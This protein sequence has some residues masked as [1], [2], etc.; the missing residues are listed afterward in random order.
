[1]NRNPFCFDRP[2]LGEDFYDR[3]G[4]I[5]EAVGLIKKP[6]CFSIIG[7]EGI[8]KTS[9][10]KRIISKEVLETYGIDLEQY[11]LVYFN[12][13][14]LHRVTEEKFVEAIYRKLSEYCDSEIESKDLFE[15]FTHLLDRLTSD[16][17][18][19]VIALDEFENAKSILGGDFSHWLRNAFQKQNVMAI[20][21][22]HRTV[23]ELEEPQSK[24]S[25]LFNIFI[26]LSLGFFKEEESQKMI[27][28]MFGKRGLSLS[29]EEISF[30][31]ELSG[32][33]PYLIQLLGNYFYKKKKKETEIDFQRFKNEM[34]YRAKD[35]FEWCWNSLRDEERRCI[36]KVRKGD[37]DFD[38]QV[39]NKMK[40]RGYLVEK[41]NKLYLF[42][43]LFLLFVDEK[44]KLEKMPSYH[45][46]LYLLKKSL[47][48]RSQRFFVI[49]A[50][51]I[52]MILLYITFQENEWAATLLLAIIVGLIAA[53]ADF[54]L[55]QV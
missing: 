13:G 30:L 12:I 28:E 34:L 6:H 23:A 41:D 21:A 5:E 1:M 15:E 22:S 25:P 14:K 19:V 2:A 55:H 26:N 42:S 46:T 52:S 50:T 39:E 45:K 38:S 9:F 37:C 8:G 33:N 49:L 36:E 31:K 17:K 16:G 32:G 3:K 10:L 18:K 20:T 29:T 40:E 48:R 44:M 51:V 24:W 43:E 53:I 11:I 47:S 27:T 54:F 35:H 4:K 7:E